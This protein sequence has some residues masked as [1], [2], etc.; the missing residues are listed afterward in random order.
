MIVLR[1][2]SLTARSVIRPENMKLELTERG[3]IA[4]PD[5]GT[6]DPVAFGDWIMTTEWPAKHMVWR[7]RDLDD[8]SAGEGRW[9]M[10]LE[11]IIN[12]LNDTQIKGQK[13]P[14][15]ITGNRK[16]TTCTAKEAVQWLLKQ[17][18][19]TDWVLGDFAFSRSEAYSFNG[20]SIFDG[21]ETISAGLTDAIWEYD[22]TKY[23]FV[24]HIRKRSE[25][26]GGEM[27]LS[28]NIV[29]PVRISTSRTGL[30]T[31]IIPIGK[32][33][34]KLP[35]GSLKKNTGLYGDIQ[36][37]E[38][39]QSMDTVEKLRS[40]AQARLDNHCEPPVSITVNGLN[41][42]RATGEDLDNIKLNRICRIP[43]PKH[44]GPIREY[45][46]RLSWAN[47]IKEPEVMTVTL[48]NNQ[49]YVTSISKNISKSG[50]R[51]ARTDAANA[52][53]DHAWF[54]D[55]N[56]HVS[57][58]AMAIIGKN[59]NG[60]DWK[61]VSELT[62]G[63]DGIFGKVDAMEG[64]VRKYGTRLEQNEK[65][66]GF[67]VGTYDDG[68]NYIK[69][70]EI[71]MAINES[72]ESEA[73]INASRIHLLGQT[74]ANQISADY[75]STK[76]AAIP[77]LNVNNMIA[78]SIKIPVGGSGSLSAVATE[79][80]VSGS[81]YNLRFQKNGDNY[82][83]Q[84]QSLG[85]TGWEDVGTFS[86]ATTLS[87]AWSG[88]IFTVDASPQGKQKSTGIFDLRNADVTWSG[89]NG[90]IAV[91][92]NMDGDET[93]RDTGKRLHVTAPF[94]QVNLA[95][96]YDRQ[97]QVYYGRLYDSAGNA[98]TSGNYYWYG[99]S[100]NYDGGSSNAAFY[101]HT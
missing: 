1:N 77:T 8:Q 91:Y 51:S 6:G 80:Y 29:G 63:A 81:V 41:L 42:S 21:L 7:V 28:R 27:R 90:T 15:D 52:E 96:A 16:A 58:V 18:T 69:A 3:S 74:I 53:E 26:I 99:S 49:T 37:Q 93:R 30:Y 38:T 98:L 67:V 57:M 73:T 35:E 33:N 34:L 95:K 43:L 76:M 59:P 66:I 40:W 64:D 71:C 47:C 44:S 46:T 70:G 48:A 36:H 85:T 62:V 13:K 20:G 45:V 86:R 31:R 68:G 101:R 92:A 23:P 75:I 65:S 78:K 54:E 9:S 87:G 11:H 10:K 14:A 17:Q 79:T 83:L 82:T 25:Q 94:S 56:D 100:T 89:L 32:N 4:S 88:G 97:D 5:F 72:G 19:V 55:T 24:L 50:G 2:N 84:K 12:V 61:R 22:T 39:D 60:V